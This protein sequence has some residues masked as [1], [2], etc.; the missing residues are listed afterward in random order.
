VIAPEGKVIL[1]PL[2]L[3]VIAGVG[4][5]AW[6]PSTMMKWVNLVLAV[7]T[8]FSLY[9]FRDPQRIPPIKEGFL[10]PAD[11]KIVQIIDIEDDDMGKAKQ[12]SIFLSVFNV[13]SQRVPYSG[14]VISKEYNPGK[15]LAA[16]NHK[17]SLDNEQTEVLIETDNGNKYKVKQIAGL[18]AR[19][20]LNYMEPDLSVERGQRLGFI[21]FGSRVD[22]I[23][24]EDFK[25]DVKMGDIVEGNLSMIGS[26]N[27][28]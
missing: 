23:L 25:I 13:H 18:I 17:A 26:F 16:F 2:L 11:G 4:V 27:E 7:I 5:N 22:I 3:L 1:I 14:K 24:P 15:F 21:R 19:R 20:I 6:N 8:V 9:F 28:N 10:S 12:I